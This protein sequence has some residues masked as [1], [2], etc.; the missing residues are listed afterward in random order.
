[1]VARPSAWA[2]QAHREV[3][4]AGRA[5]LELADL[6]S[7]AEIRALAAR[8][9][10][11]LQRLDVLVNNAGSIIPERRLTADGLE[12]TFATNHLGY[13]LLTSLLLDTLKASAP[14]R[15]VNVASDA[16]RRGHI[17]LD[18][19][20]ADKSYRPFRA[21]SDSKLANVLF[22]YELARRLAGTGVTA[23]SLHPGV[24][25]TGFGREYRGVMKLVWRIGGLF[26]ISAVQGARTIVYLASSPDV[27]GVT[28]E[29]FARC[30]P[31]TS[32]TASRDAEL[33]RRLWEASEKLTAAR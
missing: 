27:A 9:Q 22:T 1:M 3:A 13:F 8:L 4:A 26:M 25:R 11:R 5:D 10:D 19:L 31:V 28:G 24:V 32:S 7:Q 20:Q 16:H 2:E 29:Y 21:Y 17:D 12:A 33:A 14:S 23:N 18:D 6:S 15:I 30:R